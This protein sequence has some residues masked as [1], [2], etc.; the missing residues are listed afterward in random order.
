MQTISLNGTWSLRGQREEAADKRPLS[1]EATVPGCVQ[2]DLSRA[3]YL[4]EDLYMGKNILETEKFED[5]EWWY[6]R[7][8]DA[9]EKRKNVYLV[10]EGVDCIAEYYL[11]GKKIGESEN[12]Y[13]AHEFRVDDYLVDG[14]N[15]LTVHLRSAVLYGQ[16]QNYALRQLI[17]GG[18]YE[19]RH[20]RKAPHSGGWDIMC[21]C[22][23]AGLWREVRLEVRDDIYFS[24][25][26]FYFSVGR[27]SYDLHEFYY[28]LESDSLDFDGVEIELSF[29]SG[30]DSAFTKRF[31][32]T[33]RVGACRSLPIPNRKLW[34]PVGYGEP[35]V[36]EGTARIF[37]HGELVHEKAMTFG[38]R[39][40]RF[41]REDPVGGKEGKF[42]FLI[43]GVEV[44]CKGT[45]WV[46]LDAF[47]SRDA[48]RY[49]EALALVKDIG[50]NIVRCWG[51]NVYEDHKFFDF[52]DRNG[53]M[54]WQDFAMAC[55]SYPEDDRFKKLIAEEA[56]AVI[57]KL[58][59]HPS[60]IVWSGD[61]EVDSG[62]AYH[63][64][65]DENEITRELLPH[66]VR[67][68]DWNRPYL[69]SSPVITT[70][71][72]NLGMTSQIHGTTLVEDHLW[73]PRDYHKSDFY[74]NN[75]A[76]FI[77]ETGYHGCPSI[78]SIK[79]FTSP[80]KVWPYSRDNDE[81]ILHSSDQTGNPSRM[82]LMEE[83][84]KQLFGEV[85]TD[86]ESFVIASQISQAEAKKFFIERMR[87]NRPKTTGIIWW[88]LLDGWP[89]TSDAVVDYYFTKKLA[90]GYIKRSQAPFI[91]ACG[92]LSNWN[93]PLYACN[94]TLNEYEGTYKVT[95]ESTGK[96]IAE[97]SF[98]SVKNGSNVIAQLPI[99]Y[100]EKKLLLIAWE[101]NGEKGFNHYLCGYP[102]FSL[103]EYKGWIKKYDL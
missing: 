58:R 45:N 33:K 15:T 43:N 69:P 26:F 36:Y 94:D 44:M 49:D 18:K 37:R 100:S 32:V 93:L 78:E 82:L 19:L 62:S 97:G 87:V 30:E 83:Q 103:E 102:P 60:I 70:E 88:N 92:E 59:G 101:V 2:L 96:V 75:L 50:C 28:M 11:N 14:E 81:W 13:I 41:E 61:N 39:D 4:P 57:R 65:P 8:F 54:V 84:V 29:S 9:P 17:F 47:H 21:R 72:Y 74:A 46:P 86:A 51:G 10:F 64:N 3:G 56:A 27:R 42:R 66:V 34:F 38:I 80:E 73:G 89:Q 98:K 85:P 63:W 48:E 16:R 95:D 5:Y 68:N 1:L 35:N 55:A 12:M 7:T 71:M 40:V 23:T 20:I 52:C 6:E 76:R 53:I 67:Q 31:P 91:L 22:I 99:Y 79:K 25:H 24:E 77:S 90:Y